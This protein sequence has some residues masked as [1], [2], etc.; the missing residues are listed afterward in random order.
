MNVLMTIGI[1]STKKYHSS[2]CNS[3]LETWGKEL[4]NLFFITDAWEKRDNRFLKVTSKSDYKH[5]YIKTIEAIKRFVLFEE[6]T[7]WYLICDDDTYINY[8]NLISFIAGK[9]PNYPIL[10][11]QVENTWPSDPS[12]YY[13]LGGAGYVIS[14]RALERLYIEILEQ[15]NFRQYCTDF[16]DVIIGQF[17]RNKK[18]KSIHC[19]LFH[20]QKP[21]HS[22]YKYQNLEDIK[23]LKKQISF[24]Y[25]NI[26]EFKELHNKLI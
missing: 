12:L 18:I 16:N 3:I 13:C 20:G 8:N 11:G 6:Q 23:N 21:N 14:R 7:D 25:L 4:N 19:N 22:D 10:Y 9:D 5:A 2:R 24:H 26:E 15:K 17:C 1:I